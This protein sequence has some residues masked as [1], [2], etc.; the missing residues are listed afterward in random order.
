M[1]FDDWQVTEDVFND[2]DS[3]WGRHTE[4]CFATYYNRKIARYF[5][6]FWNPETSGIDAFM[7]S[8]E[9]EICWLVPPVYLIPRTLAYMYSQGAKGTLVVP[10][11][12]SA[13][14]WPLLTNIYCSFIQDLRWPNTVFKCLCLIHHY[15]QTIYALAPVFCKSQGYPQK[16]LFSHFGKGVCCCHGNSAG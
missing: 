15:F 3:L 10:L 2:L 1:D 4:D 11:W 5:F 6:R 8:W 14:F 12:K 7:Q 13:V 16:Y 9:V